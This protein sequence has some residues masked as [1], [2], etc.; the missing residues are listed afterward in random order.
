MPA[1][2]I[3]SADGAYIPPAPRGS[4]H[5]RTLFNQPPTKVVKAM[6]SYAARFPN[7]LS[8]ERGDFFY[9]VK[10]TDYY[11]EVVNPLHKVRGNVPKEFFEGLEKI[12]QRAAT[13]YQPGLPGGGGAYDRGFGQPSDD[14]GTGSSAGSFGRQGGGPGPQLG[15]G[16]TPRSGP[17]PPSVTSPTGAGGG[18]G[19]GGGGG[20]RALSAVII[21]MERRDDGRYVFAIAVTYGE[22]RRSLVYRTHDDFWQLQVSLLSHFP[23]EAGRSTGGLP[24]PRRIPFMPQPLGRDV[25]AGRAREVRA[26][27]DAYLRALLVELRVDRVAESGEVRKFLAP[28]PPADVLRY[29]GEA[30]EIGDYDDLLDEYGADTFVP[31]R[32][33][34]GGREGPPFQVPDTVRFTDLL[35]EIE[36]RLNRRVNTIAYQD[37]TNSFVNLCGD[38]DLSL[39][40]K[41]HAE[42]LVFFPS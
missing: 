34:V 28:R 8:F 14:F 24:T 11:Y 17:L 32:L 33:N 9:V 21:S 36:G 2:G 4:S 10:E 35:G 38:D 27:L 25:S 6:D 22:Y 1:G 29:D 31:V 20:D 30:T 15:M 41:T 42:K 12:A 37:E 18:V 26:K 5:P 13:R 23:S 16:G 40:I 19:G 39:L 3:V 7:E